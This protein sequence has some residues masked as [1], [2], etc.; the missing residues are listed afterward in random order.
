MGGDSL[1]K[2]DS[3]NEKRTIRIAW[4]KLLENAVFNDARGDLTKIN[5]PIV[6]FLALSFTQ[7]I[8][9]AEQFVV[10]IFNISQIVKLK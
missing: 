1:A 6:K 8:S 4:S 9:P 10:C 3:L 2:E 5:L 7:T